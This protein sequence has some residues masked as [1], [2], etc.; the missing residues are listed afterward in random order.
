MLL[1]EIK[2]QQKIPETIEL[3]NITSF[4]KG[5][6]Q[7]NKMDNERGVFGV[8]VFRYI[9]DKMIYNDEYKNVDENLTDCNVGARKE[10]NHRDNLFVIYGV[11]NSVMNREIDA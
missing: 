10:R 1:N 5:K 6:G 9:L 8:T 7:K 3:A 2:R 11:I 4:Y